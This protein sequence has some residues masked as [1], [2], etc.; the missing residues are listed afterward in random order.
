M[1]FFSP[2]YNLQSNFIFP[3]NFY[4]TALKGCLGIVFTHIVRMG[5]WGGGGGGGGGGQEVGKSFCI[6]RGSRAD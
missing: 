2:I 1:S 5:G 6:P 4:P 3:S